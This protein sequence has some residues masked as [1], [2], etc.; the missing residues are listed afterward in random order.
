MPIHP[1]NVQ[2]YG[3][4]EVNSLSSTSNLQE[5]PARPRP[6]ASAINALFSNPL[7]ISKVDASSWTQY[8]WTYN[9]STLSQCLAGWEKTTTEQ[10]LFYVSS[11]AARV[12]VISM[13]HT[14]NVAG[15]AL[16][17]S[18][19]LGMAPMYMGHRPNMT[20]ETSESDQKALGQKCQPAVWATGVWIQ[21]W[22]K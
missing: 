8:R 20:R 17:S 12:T 18:L 13:Y 7:N 1:V 9:V 4:R 15:L 16:N 14:V 10:Y 6:P 22:G 19:G 21:T 11:G 3:Y 2:L 5:D